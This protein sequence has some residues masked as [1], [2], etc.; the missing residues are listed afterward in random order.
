MSLVH[1]HRVLGDRPVNVGTSTNSN[2]LSKEK[3][4][5][6]SGIRSEQNPILPAHVNVKTVTATYLDENVSLPGTPMNEQH[7]RQMEITR[8]KRE[9]QAQQARLDDFEQLLARVK[10]ECDEQVKVKKSKG[11]P[12]P[13]K[14]GT[15]SSAVTAFCESTPIEKLTRSRLCES[16]AMMRTPLSVPFTYAWDDDSYLVQ[17]SFAG[18]ND[19]GDY[20]NLDRDAGEYCTIG[21]NDDS[22]SESEYV[23]VLGTQRDHE[24]DYV[25]IGPTTGIDGD[26]SSGSFDRVRASPGFARE[27]GD[28]MADENGGARSEIHVAAAK[29]DVKQVISLMVK[30]WDVNIKDRFGRSPLMYA[31]RYQ[32]LPTAKWLLEHGGNI[33]QQ[34]KDHSTTLHYTAYQGTPAAV[35][36]LLQHKANPRIPDNEGRTSVHWS[37]HNPDVKVLDMFL[38]EGVSNT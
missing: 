17:P 18:A 30:G 34:T 1:R 4:S 13:L 28:F 27:E 19:Q 5:T 16:N 21:P 9:L 37:M 12:T 35:R 23:E 14:L 32:Q 3:L 15:K 33:N 29:G 8:A 20:I 22:N 10:C 6:P 7:E 24:G 26:V 38:A 31:M 11:F 25:S 36:F 2:M